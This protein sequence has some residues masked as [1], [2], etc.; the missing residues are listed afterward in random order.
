MG[1]EGGGEERGGFEGGGGAVTFTSGV[2]SSVIGGGTGVDMEVGG[3]YV[4]G[5]VGSSDSSILDTLVGSS[6]EVD[7][8]PSLVQLTRSSVQFNSTTPPP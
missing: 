2:V 4:E 6:F 5:V 8:S 3:L 7:E 1:R